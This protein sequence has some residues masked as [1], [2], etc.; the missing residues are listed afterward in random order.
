MLPPLVAQCVT[1]LYHK[2]VCHDELETLPLMFKCFFLILYTQTYMEGGSRGERQGGDGGEG[3]E[4]RGESL[5]RPGDSY[6]MW[7]RSTQSGQANDGS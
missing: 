5:G 2:M 3:K 4:G 1:H 7:F 6:S